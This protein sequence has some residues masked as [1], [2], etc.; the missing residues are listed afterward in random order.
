MIGI[1]NSKDYVILIDE[2]LID[3]G[4]G[5]DEA[6]IYGLVSFRFVPVWL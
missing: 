6:C 5:C 3:S 1:Y 4:L 2:I